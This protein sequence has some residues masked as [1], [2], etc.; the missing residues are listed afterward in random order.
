MKSFVD[1]S[2]NLDDKRKQ[3][4]QKQRVMQQ[5]EKKERLELIKSFNKRKKKIKKEN[6]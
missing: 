4:M 5:L 1:F 2:E 3:L 6:N